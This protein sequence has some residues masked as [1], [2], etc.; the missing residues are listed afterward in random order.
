[1]GR[2]LMGVM[3]KPG[4]EMVRPRAR[5]VAPKLRWDPSHSTTL[6]QGWSWT[7]VAYRLESSSQ[8]KE[9]RV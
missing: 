6:P 7:A 5:P 8:G 2:P 4:K 1:M 9:K 3:T